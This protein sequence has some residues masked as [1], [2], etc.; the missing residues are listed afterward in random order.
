M[1][2]L[3]ISII[4]LT[5]F[6]IPVRSQDTNYRESYLAAESYF[7]F[8]EYNEA[9]PLYLRINRKSP[10]NDDI[11]YKIGV[12]FLNN[13]YEKEK[14]IVYLEN[15]VKNINPK[16]KE[17]NY[18]E[19]GAPL[20]SLFYL[21]NAYRINNQ[22]AK[23]REYYKIFLSR[24]DPEIYDVSLVNE[25]LAACDASENLMKQPADF[26]AEVLPEKIN[27][28]FA[29]MNPVVSG[30]ESKMAY[31]SKLQFYDAVF[32]T[33]KVDGEWGSARNIV[34]ELGV[35]GDV[36]PTFLSYNGTELLVYRNDDYIGNIYYSRLVNDKWTPLQKLGE[37]INTKYWESHASLSK[38]SKTLY[39]SSNRKYG[40][41]GLDIYKSERQENGEWGFAENLG[42]TIN[43]KY[44]DDTPFI[45]D[46]GEK[47][48]FSSYGHYN[49]GGYDNF[50]S[51]KNNEGNWTEPVNVGYPINTTDDDQFFLPIK[52]GTVF[53]YSVYTEQGYGRHDI[54]RYLVYDPE[55][56]RMFKISGLIKSMD[57]TLTM[58]DVSISV[59]DAMDSDT[60]TKVYPDTKGKFS[61]LASAGSYLLIF[62]SNKFKQHIEKID[63]SEDSPHE[64]FT[65]EKPI[66]LETHPHALTEKDI[67]EYLTLREDSIIIA[68]P[69]EKVK[70][71]FNAEPG[72]FVDISV[73]NNSIKIYKD[74]II[75]DKK[76]QSFE[77]KAL[78]GINEVIISLTD[79]L[80]SST[81]KKLLVITEEV[82]VPTIIQLADSAETI[83]DARNLLNKLIENS[84][85]NL[86]AFL[87]NIDTDALG[88]G[89]IEDLINYLLDN[90]E[91]GRI[92]SVEIS[93]ILLSLG[94]IDIA[95]IF[96][97]RLITKANPELQNALYDL[98]EQGLSISSLDDLISY[99]LKNK[100]K[101]G[102]SKE[103][104][105]E[106]LSDYIEDLSTEEEV[107]I[108]SD[109]KSSFKEGLLK[110]TLILLFEGLIIFILIFLARRKKK[111]KED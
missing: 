87:E 92:N 31:I 6:N 70:I 45:T 65:L 58:D 15:A 75:V 3:L 111:K 24:L 83:S 77:F 82:Q 9:L 84:Q 101:Y 102:Y 60:I 53:Y 94:E 8:E 16:Y 97:N 96:L 89:S 73:Y 68:Y 19:T 108:D 72:T 35:D 79:G 5:A 12:C 29:E 46:D 25:Q 37:N 47:L 110:T 57:E 11:N 62:E 106:L 61:F 34:P 64:G 28:R 67:S 109:K 40:F 105:L 27:T 104:V 26:D 95:N 52:S 78:L 88:L 80:G 17:N 51:K 90:A 81:T 22:L 63:I 49:M 39:F 18:K 23:A 54:F 20:E 4:I 2:K 69:G 99:L 38:D 55:N 100:D 66:S 107:I 44:N 71:K 33:E 74:S 59:V 21:A 76:R 43:T 86:R 41:G 14:S 36:Y 93:K 50:F 48:F 103:D 42:S 10:N 56:P 85:G 1:K 91:A 30:D 98:I 7:L 13:P 32:Y